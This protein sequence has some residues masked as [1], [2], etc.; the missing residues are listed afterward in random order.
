MHGF[1]LIEVR[2]DSRVREREYTESTILIGCVL[3]V[4]R[5]AVFYCFYRQ[6]KVLEEWRLVVTHLFRIWY[7]TWDACFK[8]AL[9]R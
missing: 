1:A 7:H 5:H 2:R 4:S 3:F 8:E 6:L 9:M